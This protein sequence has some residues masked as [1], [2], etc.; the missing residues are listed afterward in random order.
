MCRIFFN[1]IPP[2]ESQSGCICGLPNVKTVT[3]VYHFAAEKAI[4]IGTGEKA[5]LE[6][7]MVIQCGNGL[8]K[9]V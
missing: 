4:G 6:Q 7:Y 5:G 8:C 2:C 1:V 3:I 9:G